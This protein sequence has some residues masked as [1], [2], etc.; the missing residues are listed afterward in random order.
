MARTLA[1]IVVP[2]F[3]F[4]G[5]ILLSGPSRWISA[6]IC[7]AGS[8]IVM[9][10]LLYPGSRLYGKGLSAGPARNRVALTF[11]D[12]PHPV[13]TPAILSALE[14][15]GAKATFFFVGEKA[16]RHPALV[17]RAAASGHEVGA[18]SDTH[19]WWFSLASRRRLR[20]EVRESTATLAQLSGQKPRYFRPPMGH[21]GLSLEEVLREE[22]L[23]LVIWSVR[24]FDTVSRS[25][26]SIRLHL[27]DR[28]EPGGI[29]LLHEGIRRRIA[30][31][32]PTVLALPGIL[33]GLRARGLE[34]VT[35]GELLKEER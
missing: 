14:Q 12:G 27:L 3:S 19:P 33:T 18:H 34:P 13:D 4:L 1:S 35:L 8:T 20:R 25:P 24:P 23:T 11:D 21:R 16:R 6:A 28:A 31:V 7:I 10:G 17:R 15:S 29:L 22:G 26:D 30:G 2:L 32:S 5:T 9:F